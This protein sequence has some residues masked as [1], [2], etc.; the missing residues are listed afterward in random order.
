[1]PISD[2]T[3]VQKCT[4]QQLISTA[5]GTGSDLEFNASNFLSIKG[6]SIDSSKIAAGAVTADKIEDG[7]IDLTKIKTEGESSFPISTLRRK[8]ICLHIIITVIIC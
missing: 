1:M 8:T 2:G 7:G 5:L 3:D 4:T 6:G